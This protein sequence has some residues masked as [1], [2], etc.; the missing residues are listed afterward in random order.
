MGNNLSGNSRHQGHRVF[1]AGDS[2]DCTTF[3]AI[4]IYRKVFKDCSE[5]ADFPADA[6]ASTKFQVNGSKFQSQAILCFKYL[7]L[8]DQRQVGCINITIC[9]YSIS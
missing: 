9:K 8:K 2:T 5:S 7:R 1:R 6:T 4:R 3:A